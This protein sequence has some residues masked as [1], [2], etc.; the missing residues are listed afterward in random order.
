MTNVIAIDGPSY[1]GKSTVARSL[2]A[3]LGYDFINTGHMFRAVA[4]ECVLKNVS[5]DT[6]NKV[7]ELADQLDIQFESSEKG[8]SRTLINGED[9]TEGLERHDIMLLA[10]KVAQIGGVRNILTGKQRSYADKKTIVMEGRDIGSLV[11]PDA[12]WKFFIT[13]SME[14]RAK[15]MYKIMDKNEKKNCSDYRTLIPKLEEIDEADRNRKISPLR[16][17]EDAIVYDNSDSPDE[18]QDSLILKYYITHK[19]EIIRNTEILE[20]KK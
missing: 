7:V 11:F 6:E 16:I 18:H 19:D 10:A 12:K 9:L 8:S 3:Q 5:V 2:A 14:I 15:R 13:A 20:I 1:V 17:A 4:R